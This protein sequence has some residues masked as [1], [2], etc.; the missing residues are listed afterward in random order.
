MDVDEQCELCG[1]DQS[2]S[3]LGPRFDE[4]RT[5]MDKDERERHTSG[6]TKTMHHDGQAWNIGEVL[7]VRREEAIHAN[8]G[9]TG[10]S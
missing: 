3:K 1:S 4:Q 8:L 7:D 6:E 2:M 5:W 9:R 10:P